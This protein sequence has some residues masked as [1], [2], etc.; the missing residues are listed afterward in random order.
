MEHML[1]SLENLLDEIGD[2]DYEVEY[3]V[4]VPKP[5]LQHGA[6]LRSSFPARAVS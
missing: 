3:S 6:A 1:D 5:P 4:S 2:P